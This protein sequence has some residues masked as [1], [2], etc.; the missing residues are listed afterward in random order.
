MK[1]ETVNKKQTLKNRYIKLYIAAGI[2]FFTIGTILL[3]INLLNGKEPEKSGKLQQSAD[4][5]LSAESVSFRKFDDRTVE[6]TKYELFY[7]NES[8][9]TNEAVE[10]FSLIKT[11]EKYAL[12]HHLEQHGYKWDDETRA[13]FRERIISTLE[14]DKKDPNLNVYLK[15]MFD[16]LQITEEEYIDHY[17]LVNKEFEMLYQDLFNKGIG[18]DETGAYPSGE[19][20]MAYSKLMGITEDEMNE[21]A[22]KIPQPLDPMEPQPDLPF[23]TNDSRLKVTKNA[24][25]E[26]IFVD[27][28]YFTLEFDEPYREILNNLNREVVK[29]ELTGYSLKRYQEAVVSYDSEDAQKMKIVKEFDL[30]LEIL[31]RTIEMELI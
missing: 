27:S 26:Y 17:Q 6:I 9:Y 11:I 4:P 8:F 25:G 19:A 22:E 1:Q 10:F 5:Q 14:Y 15:K 21:L 24:L 3:S 20:E 28:M 12:F 18:L 2:L 31:E 23:I 7:R 29:E 16:E 30:I 13:T